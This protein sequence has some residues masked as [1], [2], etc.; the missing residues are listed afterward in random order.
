M[1][2]VR[3]HRLHVF[4]GLIGATS[5][6]AISPAVFAWMSP[7]ILGLLLSPITAFAT[8]KEVSGTLAVLLATRY[9]RD[10]PAHHC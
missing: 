9:E 10:S 4:W 1:Q 7:I 8:A 6:W 2:F 5:C 3:S